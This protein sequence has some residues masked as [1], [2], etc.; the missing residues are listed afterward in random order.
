M[1]CGY[2]LLFPS[3]V[4]HW[5]ILITSINPQGQIQLWLMLIY[6]PFF[7]SYLILSLFLQSSVSVSPIPFSPW[8]G[9]LFLLNKRGKE[10]QDQ[11][12]A[13]MSLILPPQAVERREGHRRIFGE[14]PSSEKAAIQEYLPCRPWM[15]WG[16]CWLKDALML[17]AAFI[18]LHP[19]PFSG[20]DS[21]L[22]LGSILTCQHPPPASVALA[23]GACPDYPFPSGTSS[24]LPCFPF[25]S[26]IPFR[27]RLCYP[28]FSLVPSF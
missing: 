12:F 23:F 1:T 11:L 4:S 5:D 3:Q 22:P 15:G 10:I 25:I 20:H 6:P 28:L 18:N 16:N 9:T 19:G 14:V 17:S 2:G 24:H 27:P 8:T 13:Y 7:L 26:L 21:L